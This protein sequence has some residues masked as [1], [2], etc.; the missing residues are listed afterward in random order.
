M[1]KN[2]DVVGIILACGRGNRFFT[3]QDFKNNIPK[4]YLDLA[5][6]SIIR[7]SILAFLNH[8]KID[9]VLC[10]IHPEDVEN[11]QK[12]TADLASLSYIFGGERRQD[13]IRI[14]LEEIKKYQPKN[15]LIHDAV[16]PMIDEK[17]ISRVIDKLTNYEERER[18]T[19]AVIPVLPVSDTIKKIANNQIISTL[20]RSDLFLVQTPQGFDYQEILAAHQK[21]QNIDF[22]DD[23]ALIEH[24]GNK[25]ESV[26]GDADNFKITYF[27][28]YQKAQKMVKNM[29]EKK[30]FSRKEN[31][32]QKFENK[33]GIGFDVHR[34]ENIIEK[35]GI[36]NF[37]TIGGVEIEFDKKIIAHSD[38]DVLIHALMDAILGAIAKGDIGQHFPPNDEKWRNAD[39]RQMLKIISDLAK[40]EGAKIVNIDLIIMAE[41]PKILPHKEKMIKVLAKILAVNENKINIKATTTEKLGFLGRGE[42]IAAQ[43]IVSIYQ[44]IIW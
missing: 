39:S 5:G 18:S 34:F 7:R 44:T 11:Y 30:D 9:K 36:K 24:A 22:T 26:E 38:G 1:I 31:L 6:I 21:Y 13:S 42:G 43:A 19:K 2:V 16:R 41:A 32:D 37:I 23:A 29:I 20:D 28:D 35:Q 4:Q 10:V 40:E 27:A 33:V 12:N 17:T 14:A 3:T 25:V 15:V 8:T